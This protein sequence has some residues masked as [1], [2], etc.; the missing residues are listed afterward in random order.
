MKSLHFEGAMTKES[1]ERI[2]ERP[3]IVFFLT[4]FGLALFLVI[5]AL[6]DGEGASNLIGTYFLFGGAIVT[7]IGFVF[8]NKGSNR[9]DGYARSSYM[10]NQE[11]F[12][13][14]RAQ[15][16]PFERVMWA[17]ILAALLLAVIGYFLNLL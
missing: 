5:L 17:I 12:K 6:F 4:L 3:L 11:Y 2:F 1:N 16:K 8:L 7:I 14:V 15:E 9:G 10:N 13:K